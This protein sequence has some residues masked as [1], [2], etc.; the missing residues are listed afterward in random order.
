[1]ALGL[2]AQDAAGYVA[3]AVRAL[4]R[5][6]GPPLQGDVTRRA[7]IAAAVAEAA[8]VFWRIDILV[9]NAGIGLRKTLAESVTED[10]FDATLAVNLKGTFFVSRKWD[11]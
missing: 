3:E 7:E 9:N 4:G 8:Q 11:G 5:R 1:M 6:G 10:D 2:R